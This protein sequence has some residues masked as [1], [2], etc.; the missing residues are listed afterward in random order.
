MYVI[1]HNVFVHV[2]I[3]MAKSN[4]NITSHAY[5]FFFFFVVRTLKIY[6]AIFECMICGY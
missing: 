5:H 3:E 1:Q 6:S 2:K 4:I